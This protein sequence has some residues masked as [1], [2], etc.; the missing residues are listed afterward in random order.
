[1]DGKD[2][3]SCMCMDGMD[4]KHGNG[5]MERMG[6]HA[7]AWMDAW[8]GWHAWNGWMCS[9]SHGYGGVKKTKKKAKK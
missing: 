3:N 1:M 4:G 2:G 6:I 8:H 7:C 5:W 9:F